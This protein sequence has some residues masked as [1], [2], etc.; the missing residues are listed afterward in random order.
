MKNVSLKELNANGQLICSFKKVAF[1]RDD[2]HRQPFLYQ[3]GDPSTIYLHYYKDAY[4]VTQYISS[5]LQVGFYNF[6]DAQKMFI[7]FIENVK[8]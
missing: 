7:D 6:C 2:E 8:D 4:I 3:C 1:I 5:T